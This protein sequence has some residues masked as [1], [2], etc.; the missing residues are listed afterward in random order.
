MNKLSQSRKYNIS[1]RG[2]L[3]TN[4]SSEAYCGISDSYFGTLN[5]LIQLKINKPND[6]IVNLG[7]CPNVWTEKRGEILYAFIRDNTAIKK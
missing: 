2:N 1:C 3:L 5:C 4:L 6:Q 7:N